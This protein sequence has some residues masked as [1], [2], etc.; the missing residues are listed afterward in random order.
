M[1]SFEHS[2]FLSRLVTVRDHTIG[3]QIALLCR[4]R[5]LPALDLRH[6]LYGRKAKGLPSHAVPSC[7]DPHLDF[8]L[9]YDQVSFTLVQFSFEDASLL[10][11]S[12]S[13]RYHKIG[14]MIIFTHDVT[15]ILLEMTKCHVYLQKRNGK[16]HRVHDLL[17]KIGFVA[18]ALAWFLFRL[19][20]FPLKL[21]YTA[22][23]ASGHR[24]YQRQASWYALFNLLLW[25]L[26]AM[27]IYWFY[28]S[29]QPNKS[30]NQIRSV[31]DFASQFVLLFLYKIATK[32]LK[33]LSDTREYE[34]I[35]HEKDN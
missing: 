3:H 34:P 28:V 8:G 35:E 1:K 2:Q 6:S 17:S 7:A 15:D 21:L 31:I 22:S 11:S 26:L 12:C 9:L 16:D 13:A 18:F 19:Y 29:S 32:Q 25:S 14:I 27:D 30:S 23:A 33:E 4:M 20:W 5:L 24:A 10:K